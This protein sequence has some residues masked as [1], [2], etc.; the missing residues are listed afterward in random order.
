RSR[1]PSGVHPEGGAVEVRRERTSRLEKDE[2]A[3]SNLRRSRKQARLYCGVCGLAEI[4]QAD[5]H[6]A[7][8]LS[9][10]RSSLSRRLRPIAVSSSQVDGVDGWSMAAG[11]DLELTGLELENHRPCDASFLARSGPDLFRKPSNQ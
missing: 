4:A 7:K 1:G 6:Q 8:T 9:G 10:P 3:G 2:S 5:T 11:E